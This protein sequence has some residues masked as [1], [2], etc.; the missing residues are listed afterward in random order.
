MIVPSKHECFGLIHSA[1]TLDHIVAHSIQVCRV[2]LLIADSLQGQAGCLNRSIVLAG[3][4]LHDI[5][6]TRSLTTGE[7]HAESGGV[8]LSGKGFPEV[9][10]VVRQHVRLDTFHPTGPVSEAEIVNYADKRV[11]HDRIAPLDERMAYILERY[12]KT[13]ELRDRLNIIWEETV[14]LEEKL[15]RRLPFPPSALTEQLP[16]EDRNREMKEY[17][18]SI[19]TC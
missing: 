14:S 7:R 10:A 6:K 17:A 18:E 4:L 5:T 15:F 1:G 13:P 16:D 3:A 8:Y 19:L 2:A 9:A 12:G 11:I